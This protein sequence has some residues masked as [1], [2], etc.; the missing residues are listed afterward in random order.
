[1]KKSALIFAVASL[2][3]F[4]VSCGGN[5]EGKELPLEVKLDD[6]MA[7]EWFNQSVTLSD[8]VTYSVDKK[9]KGEEGAFSRQDWTVEVPFTVNTDKYVTPDPSVLKQTIKLDALE[10]EIWDE[11][12]VILGQKGYKVS[13]E[14]ALAFYDALAKGKDATGVL[15]FTH[16]TN[17]SD[18]CDK[19][20]ESAAKFV[21]TGGSSF[22]NG[23]VPANNSTSKGDVPDKTSPSKGGSS[24]EENYSSGSNYHSP[25]E[26]DK[27][28][29]RMDNNEM[30]Y[31]GLNIPEY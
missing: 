31:E 19:W 25:F 23:G 8:K 3:L 22:I 10:G 17:N 7:T 30:D 13:D 9:E 4:A 5:E 12:K 28:S 20:Y 2:S 21:I 26:V 27:E 24:M 11:Q 15:K 29:V 16:W 6:P 14:D 1:M 18:D